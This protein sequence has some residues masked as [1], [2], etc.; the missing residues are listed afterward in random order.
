MQFLCSNSSC[1]LVSQK[2]KTSCSNIN[3]YGVGC[4]ICFDAILRPGKPFLALLFDGYSAHRLD[5]WQNAWLLFVEKPFF[6][7]G[8][9][10]R[11]ELLTLNVIYHEHN[12]FV[13]V[14]VT[15]GIMGLFA[16]S[17]MLISVVSLAL[18][19]KTILNW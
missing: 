10:V 15:M 17:G 16:Y 2:S 11:A 13:S 6:G 7:H 19:L 1:S 12:I 8:L 5:I 4:R 14:G 18:S 9:D 3:R